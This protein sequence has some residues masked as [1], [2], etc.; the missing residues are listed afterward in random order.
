MDWIK[1]AKDLGFD[2]AAFFNPQTLQAREDVREMCAADKCHSYNK[3][4]TCPPACGT[5][6]ECQE[7][8][9]R[10]ANGL[11]LQTTGHLKTT[12]DSKMYQLTGERH[13]R[14]FSSFSDLIRKTYPDSLCL[15][16]G[17]CQVCKTCAYPDPCRF[18]DRA[19]SSMEAY[20]LFVIHVCKEAGLPYYYGKNTITYTACVLYN[21][22]KSLEGLHSR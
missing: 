17:P 4:W 9:T 22:A 16:A 11:L 12:F 1:K 15:G 3:S 2:A 10:Y 13:Q 20:G 5:I 7:K 6:E 8:M 18:P 19:L 21:D 14:N